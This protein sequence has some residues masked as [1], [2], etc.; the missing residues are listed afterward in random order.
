VWG[1]GQI[2]LV[3]LSKTPTRLPEAAF[4]TFA[5]AGP[6]AERTP[7]LCYVYYCVN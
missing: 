4:V 6:G 1:G 5:P 2:A 7:L 3:A